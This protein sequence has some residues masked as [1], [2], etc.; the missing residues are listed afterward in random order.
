MVISQE[1]QRLKRAV[2]LFGR[3]R[4]ALWTT[5]RSYADLPVRS[6][7]LVG[8]EKDPGEQA[9][10]EMAGIINETINKQKKEKLEALGLVFSTLGKKPQNPE[11][12]RKWSASRIG[13]LISMMNSKPHGSSYSPETLNL[14]MEKSEIAENSD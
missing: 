5:L 2:S 13:E 8:F 3:E 12:L 4:S 7:D 9:R 11:A 10:E 6:F 1:Y 14:L